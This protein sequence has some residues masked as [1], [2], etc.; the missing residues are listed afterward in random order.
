MHGRMVDRY[1][2]RFTS[3]AGKISSLGSCLYLLTYTSAGTAR[4]AESTSSGKR[5]F[6]APDSNSSLN[7]RIVSPTNRQGATKRS[8]LV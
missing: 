6:A 5:Y 8:T 2:R 3:S 1:Q 7:W 4:S